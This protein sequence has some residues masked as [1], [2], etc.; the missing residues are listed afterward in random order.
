[1]LDERLNETRARIERG[2]Q[3]KGRSVSVD[4]GADDGRKRLQL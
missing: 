1:M 4:V 3:K 2:L